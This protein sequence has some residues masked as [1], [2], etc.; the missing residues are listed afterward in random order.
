[1][2]P[3]KEPKDIFPDLEKISTNNPQLSE[4]MPCFA[5]Q[6]PNGVKH[7]LWIYVLI[8]AIISSIIYL[9]FPF[10]TELNAFAAGALLGAANA[11]LAQSIHQLFR[12]KYS[13]S[14]L[15]MFCVWGAFNGYATVVWI[16]FL[17]YNFDTPLSRVLA[18]QAFGT[19]F[20]QLAFNILSSMWDHNEFAFSLRNF[21]RTLKY[22]YCFWPF[23]SA[24]LFYYIPIKYMLPANCLA[25]LAWNVCLSLI[26]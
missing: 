17:L 26:S 2:S 24:A 18:D 12:L 23:Y 22:S 8:E 19:P 9:N 4:P 13:L 16:E 21:L 10:L 25:T 1:M 14:R 20:F 3:V 15:F 5:P 6:T 7:K 11:M